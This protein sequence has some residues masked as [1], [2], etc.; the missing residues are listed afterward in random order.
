MLASDRELGLEVHV[1]HAASERDFDGVFAKLIEL[2]AAGL[3]MTVDCPIKTVGFT[4]RGQ[5]SAAA[6]RAHRRAA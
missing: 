3:V 1:L 5:P 4:R 2:H 6:G